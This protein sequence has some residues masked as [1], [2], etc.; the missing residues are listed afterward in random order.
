MKRISNKTCLTSYK[1]SVYFKI[2]FNMKLFITFI[3]IFCVCH[4]LPSVENSPLIV[5]GDDAVEG[6]APFMVSVQVDRQANDEYRHTC[7]GSI[8]SPVWIL[9]AAHCATENMPLVRPL[10]IVAGE[11]NFAAATG[12]EQIRLTPNLLIHSNYTGGVAPYDIMLMEAETPLQFISGVVGRILLPAANS[13]PT[14]FVRL[15]GWGSISMTENAIIPDI[16]QTVEKDVLSLD[17]CIEVLNNKFPGGTP[18]HFTNICT[19]P[20]DSIITACSGDSGGPIV[21]GVGESVNYIFLYFPLPKTFSRH[22]AIIMKTVLIILTLSGLIFCH[23]TVDK[24]SKIVGG[25]NAVEHEAPFMVTLQVDR[26][27]DGNFRHTCGGS[28][29]NPNWILSAAHCITENGLE[30]DYQIIAGQHNLNVVSGREQI[31]RVVDFKIH[32]NFISG[33]VVG[34]YDVMVLRL[35][36]PL[37]FFT[38]IVESINLPLSGS[39][40]TGDVQLFGWG[41]T[42]MTNV[43][44]IPDILQTVRKDIIPFD[45]CREVVNQVFD[46]EPLHFTNVCTGPLDSVITACSGDSGG[47]IVQE[48][49]DGSLQ[50]IGIASW[51]SAFPCGA[52]NALDIEMKAFVIFSLIVVTVSGLPTVDRNTRV[53]GGRPALE[54]EA[55]YIISLQ[56][57]PQGNGAFRHVCGGS[58]I[59]PTW[60]L[61]AAH[62]VTEVGFQFQYQIVAGQHDLSVSSGREQTRRVIKF[63]IHENFVSGPVVGPFDIMVLELESSLEL[64]NGVVELISLPPSGR[65]FSGDA[66]LFGW[67]STSETTTP[68]FPDILQTVSKPIV[69]FELCR[70]I[71]NAVF[72]HEPLHSSNLC[73]GPLD[74]V[75]SA[76]N[77]DSGG[78]LVQAGDDGSLDVVGIVS[79][80][81]GFPC[82]SPNSVTVYIE[83]RAM[84]KS[85]GE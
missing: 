64:V 12:R 57:D 45:L 41:S 28:I 61:S 9:S 25:E 47:P 85:Y 79:W 27:G 7:G 29:L 19:G 37:N 36:S 66:R 83:R 11:H 3:F 35:E 71:V 39:I 2:L 16:M 59:M 26:F 53:V 33:P 14:G 32:E 80:G 77:G 67:G 63:E 4:A 58:I 21:Q 22:C 49:P 18:I 34:P 52:I 6:A 55:P 17:L 38:G 62:C 15:F 5:G 30:L 69:A 56:V 23:P 54:H 76:C 60:I 40:P 13:I 82:G 46:H 72:V 20:L 44:S 65:I 43:P 73:T 51:I 24:G 74:S 84:G 50:V 42:S 48:G 68:S 1:S 81:S 78:P 10:R 70:E 8:L 31:R 75:I